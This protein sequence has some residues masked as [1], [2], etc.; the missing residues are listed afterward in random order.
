M[1]AENSTQLNF[2]EFLKKN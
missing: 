1:L 2:G